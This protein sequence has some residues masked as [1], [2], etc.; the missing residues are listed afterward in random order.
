MIC[1]LPC[2]HRLFCLTIGFAA[3]NNTAY[4]APAI[5]DALD[6]YPG[7]EAT[8]FARDPEMASPTNIDVDY[9]GRVWVCEVINYGPR[10]RK[11]GDRILILEDT[12]GDGTAETTKVFYQGSDVDAAM[13]ICVLGNRVIVTSAPNVLVLIDDDGDDKADRKEY[14]F[15]KSGRPRY[16]H[17][18]HSVTFGPDG[19]L[20]WNTGN[21]GMAIYDSKGQ[22]VQDAFG[23]DVVDRARHRNSPFWGGMIFRCNLDGSQFEVLGHNFRNNYELAVDSFGNIWQSDNDDDGNYGCRLNYILEYGNYGY[24]DEL[25]GA[26]WGKTRVSQHP[27]VRRRHWHQ[28]DPGVIPNF[29]QTGAGSPAGITVYEGDLLPPVFRNEVIHCDAGPGVVWAVKAE[30]DGAGY[31][32]TTLNLLKGERDKQVRPVDV[33]VG[34]DG[35]VFV[36]DWYDPV[37]GWIR[38]ADKEQGRIYRI[39]PKG[40]RSTKP[41]LDVSTPNG[42]VMALK[43]PNG[44]ARYRGWTALHAME[45]R[46]EPALQKLFNAPNPRWRGRALWLLCRINGR[47]D[48]YIHQG[49]DDADENVRLVALRAARQLDQELAP[50]IRRS[51][52]D[53]SARL[54]A[55]CAI[56]LRHLPAD[57]AAPLWVQLADRFAG[58][59]RWL[60]EA[61]G[62]GAQGRWDAYLTAWLTRHPDAWHTPAGRRLIWR[63]R[64]SRTPE[65]LGRL[66][67]EIDIDLDE[68]KQLVRAFDFQDDPEATRKVLRKIALADVEKPGEPVSLMK[69]EAFLRLAG[70]EGFDD[71]PEVK[72]GLN[73]FVTDQAGSL[74]FVR[75]IQA[76]NLTE[77][78]AELVELSLSDREPEIANAALS[79]L[80]EQNGTESLATIL[81]SKDND[82]IETVVARLAHAR[83][84]KAV[85]MLKEVLFNAELPSAIREEAVRGLCATSGGRAIVFQLAEKGQFPGSL[86]TIAGAA[87]AKTTHVRHRETADRL[88][89]LP[90]LKGEM[91]L[92]Q[93]TELLVFVGN[94]ERGRD[95]FK[96]ATCVACHR[97]NEEGVNFGP[98]L[99]QIGEKLSKQGLYESIL[100]PSAGI[101]Q[102]YQAVDMK[103]S[104][105][106]ELSGFITSETDAEIILRQP[107]AVETTLSTKD[108]VSRETSS[109]SLMPAG[110]QA[111]LTVD[112]LVDLVEYL[113][114][115]RP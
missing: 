47:T 42:A 80:L 109:V 64:S 85:G 75:L 45:A 20:Y 30:R 74:R 72:K 69:T 18:I 58:Q 14:L 13:G 112:E 35:A 29:A 34:P 115:L 60:L 46:A 28:N 24:R 93:M 9:R 94:I 54:L 52:D 53:R 23:N 37:L 39:A 71:D 81:S 22:L 111:L 89:P 103:L 68:T 26:G 5:E 101:S 4:T 19:K 114:S 33:A 15:T 106:R 108:I 97:V 51:A 56:A 92:P 16:D 57:D 61:L 91:K 110:L 17:S 10:P 78:N 3:I 76:F 48:H 79:L 2:I 84:E 105:D 1:M 63:S 82:R 107:G 88:F 99:S 90:A 67:M 66:L 11:G 41:S 36:S 62:I 59:D 8:V 70:S 104:D 6:L 83:N 43:S 27:D 113:T 96:K 44:D 7:L 100:D 49:L 12:D 21:T 38:Q 98:D 87:L 95:A 32:G 25:T 102:T 65:L 77:F 55:E 50:L 86:R 31:R 40:Y 73:R